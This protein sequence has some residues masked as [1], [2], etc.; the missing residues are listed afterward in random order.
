MAMPQLVDSTRRN[1]PKRPF[2][3]ADILSRIGETLCVSLPHP[4]AV[5]VDAPQ[6]AQPFDE[7]RG[8]FE[9][10]CHTPDFEP[11]RWDGLS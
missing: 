6:R 7:A 3:S 1:P 11:E 10:P 2:A 8:P 4:N 9:P 5:V